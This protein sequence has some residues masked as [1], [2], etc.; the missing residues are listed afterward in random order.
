MTTPQRRRLGV[1]LYPVFELLDVFGPLEMFGSLPEQVEITV[2]AERP[3]PVASFQGPQV[4][5]THGFADCPPIDLLLVPGG[6]GTR[7]Q[8][9]NAA[10]LE[11]LRTRAARAEVTMSVCSGSALL[12]IAGLLDGRRATSNKMFFRELVASGPHVE[13]VPQA[14]WVEDGSF[15]TS[16]GVSAGIDMALAVIAKLFGEKTSEDLAL[17]TEYEWHR[18]ASWDPFA[19]AHGLA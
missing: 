1:V 8:I 18:D 16:S 9:G 10:M 19:R 15:Y 11:F 4:V 6:F 17:A 13:W 3:G 7:E 12:A 5:A 2:I 14:R